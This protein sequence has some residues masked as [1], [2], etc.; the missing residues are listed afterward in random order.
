MMRKI[1]SM[2]E[3]KESIFLLEI[4]KANEARLL[5]EQFMITYENIK[6]VNLIKNSF[7]ELITSPHLKENL[8]NTTL[9]IAAGYLSKKIAVGST[10]NPLKQLLGTFLQLGVTNIVSRNTDGIKSSVM[11]LINNFFS[12]NRSTD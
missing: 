11:S 5:K 4:K 1:T 2:T 3:L 9:S 8:L 6:P 12:K 7:N 10:H